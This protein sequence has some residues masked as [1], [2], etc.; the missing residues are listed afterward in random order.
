MPGIW[1]KGG[2]LKPGFPLSRISISCGLYHCYLVYFISTGQK[3]WD[4]QTGLRDFCAKLVPQFLAISG[5]RYEYEMNVLLTCSRTG[6]L[7]LEEEIDTIYIKM[8]PRILIQWGIPI[9][10]IKK[11]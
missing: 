7:I 6:I 2:Q 10:C 9:V 11:S 3:V 1:G 4:T 8:P 5:K